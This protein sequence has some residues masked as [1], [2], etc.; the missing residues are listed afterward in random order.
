MKAGLFSINFA[1]NLAWYLV[2]HVH[3]Y[4][5]RDAVE[6]GPTGKYSIRRNFS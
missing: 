2:Q 3:M 4:T 5:H 1:E 6:T